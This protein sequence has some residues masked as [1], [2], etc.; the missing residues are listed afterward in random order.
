MTGRFWMASAV[1][2]L[3]VSVGFAGVTQAQESAESPDTGGKILKLTVSEAI[4]RARAASLRQVQLQSLHDAAA[5]DARVAR[6][7]RL[8]S[9]DASASYQRYSNVPEFGIEGP[10]GVREILAPN[11]P[12]VSRVHVG[13]SLPLY[14]G[15]RLGGLEKAATAEA[16]ATESDVAAGDATLL[17]ETRTAY[18]RLVTAREM[19]RVLDEALQ[20]YEAHLRD[21]RNYE[22][23]GMA[24]RNEVLSVEAER[25]R[26][27]L[28]LIRARNAA[29]VAQANLAR[30]LDLAPGVT[31]DPT[32]PLE[33]APG[34]D[35]DLEGLV[36]AALQ[37]R[38]ECAALS[39]RLDAARALVGAER[40][41]RLPQVVA[42]AGWDYQNP[43]RL[44]FPPEAGWKDTWNVGVAAQISIFDGGQAAAAT[45]R[46]RARVAAVE[47]QLQDLDR[48]VRLEV[49]QRA[50]DLQ[51]AHV[52]IKVAQTGLDAA[53]ESRRVAA[54]R[55]HEGLIP[56]SELL[57]AEVAQLRAGLNRADSLAQARLAAAA[58][59]RA[60][61]R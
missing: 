53:Q 22:A 45:A 14:T 23:E 31:V 57:D 42:S 40:A 19:A 16:D 34:P 48:H 10:G 9:L 27:R 28:D 61:G 18:W 20:A 17:L 55:Y 56:S 39:A 21:A 3:A 7:R 59:D 15:G 58:L 29:S 4:E 49:T 5:A 60:V 51:A 2:C 24:A 36:A 6:G 41:A 13:A 33:A 11:L 46:A 52:A 1:G 26:S 35:E 50:L 44:Y 30:L 32:E 43:N 54:E 25:E 37:H 38:P 47:A 8:P 12:N